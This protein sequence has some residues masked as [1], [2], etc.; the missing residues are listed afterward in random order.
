MLSKM[1]IS[2]H[3]MFNI[4]EVE[5]EAEAEVV[6]IAD[7]IGVIDPTLIGIVTIDITVVGYFMIGGEDHIAVVAITGVN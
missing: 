2:K 3:P 5:V 4:I 1:A 7:R 6:G